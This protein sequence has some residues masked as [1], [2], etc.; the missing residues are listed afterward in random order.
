ME[1]KLF[2]FKFLD[3]YTR[4]DSQF[5]FGRD[6]EI[7]TM[8]DMIFQT[9]L[10]VVYGASGTGKT[11]LVQCGLANRF[12]SHDWYSLF[13]RRGN[14]INES[15]TQALNNAGG[16]VP[17]ND[18]LDWLDQDWTSDETQQ[19]TV[20]KS[21]T[22]KSI[23]NVYS[24]YFRPIYL[25]FDQFEELF[26]LGSKEEQGTFYQTIREILQLEQ[27]VKIILLL[28][29]E[30]LGHMYDFER[31]IPR[32]LKKKL[33]IEPM[34]LGRVT[35]II[36]GIAQSETSLVS[37]KA[38]EE[39]QIAEIVFNKIKGPGK[40]ISIDL[41][42]LQVFLNKLYLSITNDPS[43]TTPAEF[44]I[45]ALKDIG[46]IGDV[47]RDLIDEQVA[48]ASEK[49]STPEETVWQVLSSLVTIDGTKESL[50]LPELER[51]VPQVDKKLVNRLILYFI[52]QRI[53]RQSPN[54]TIFELG[55]DTLAKQ[56]HQKR[57]DEQLALLEVQRLIRSQV[58][59][60]PESREFFSE[61]QLTFIKPF[62]TQYTPS[63]EEMD[64]LNKSRKHA[65]EV[66]EME[67]RKRMEELI[68]TR[69]RLRFFIF[70]LMLSFIAIGVAIWQSHQANE[71][72]DIAEEALTQNVRTEAERLYAIEDDS[73]RFQ[74]AAEKY[75]YIVNSLKP[76]PEDY[77][78][79]GICYQNLKDY[80]KAEKYFLKY[81]KCDNKCPAANHLLGQLY[82]ETHKYKK[83]YEYELAATKHDTSGNYIYW[84]DLS[85]YSLFVNK[86]DQALEAA[87]KVMQLQPAK[88]DV[89]R[90]IALGH[91]L[92]GN[93]GKAESTYHKWMNKVFQDVDS[94]AWLYSTVLFGND[95][96]ELQSAGV[97]HKDF[98][99][100]S[101]L[102]TQ[103]V[104]DI[105]NDIPM[106]YIGGNTFLMG[107]DK[108]MPNIVE[109]E[110][111]RHSVKLDSYYIGKTEVTQKLWVTIMGNN[112]S[113]LVAEDHPVENISWLDAQLFLK[114]LNT[115]TGKDYRLPTE[116]EW[117]YAAQGGSQ[118]RHYKFC[119]SNNLIEVGWFKHPGAVNE[120]HPVGQLKPN[121][122]GIYDMSGNV[123]EWCNDW[124]GVYND[125][126]DKTKKTSAYDP[127]TRIWNPK[128][129]VYNPQG[130]VEQ[131]ANDKVLRGG[132][133]DSE[134]SRCR[135]QYRHRHKTTDCGS[136]YGMRIA[137][138]AK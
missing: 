31:V 38:G 21:P 17:G 14:D 55:H 108:H 107:S 104:N 59:I 94:A 92:N 122:L 34:N 118:S 81:L 57:S 110:V 42:Y 116:A 120:S 126:Y 65:I 137:L 18:D 82:Y 80:K 9:D 30:Y 132:S 2:P 53:I 5:Y 51:R 52:T 125:S 69:K 40:R 7:N 91:L 87:K 73:L 71:A 99:K 76:I 15:L 29:E 8:Y 27:P 62:L 22:A 25:I 41:P 12:E 103:A 61:K 37:I 47:L 10:L 56:I 95:I 97:N 33:R 85:H 13:I 86:P 43:H 124:Y 1:Q 4:E 117:E 26:I 138:S 23:E 72:R 90:Y 96:Q 58:A 45:E 32:L 121:E 130:H 64:W 128:M 16:E 133:Y 127:E 48:K 3:S 39:E 111:P 6:E 106:I 66:S 100:V 63:D 89:E 49:F 112:P 67:E 109:N 24:Q 98:D 123:W 136:F 115:I 68:K 70:L 114:R 102:L 129:P 60:K 46:D 28:R 19:P 54:G 35:A 84:Y 77:G 36:K 135:V 44:S 11:S 74:N 83:A 78:S 131:G 93:W 75:L 113:K 119:G 79:L 105:V 50:T 20:K 88:Q 101:I 134:D